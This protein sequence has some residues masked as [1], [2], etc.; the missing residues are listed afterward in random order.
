MVNLQAKMLVI[1]LCQ[2]WILKLIRRPR[3]SVEATIDALSDVLHAMNPDKSRRV[4]TDIFVTW[5]RDE[6]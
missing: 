1:L 6:R 3:S 2:R 4:F 5:T